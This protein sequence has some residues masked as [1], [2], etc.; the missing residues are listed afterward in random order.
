LEHWDEGTFKWIYLSQPR[1]W[2]S[3]VNTVMNLRIL[4]GVGNFLAGWGTVSFCWARLDELIADFNA[5][6][7][8]GYVTDFEDRCFLPT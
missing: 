8:N 7:S 2:R 3:V 6:Y 5:Q 4:W 1:D